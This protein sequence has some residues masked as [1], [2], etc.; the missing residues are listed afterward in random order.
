MPWCPSWLYNRRTVQQ[1]DYA[2]ISYRFCGRG[3]QGGK[4]LLP[5]MLR[6]SHDSVIQEAA[7]ELKNRYNMDTQR[8]DSR[9]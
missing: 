9:G 7:T 1:N 5:L 8:G 4:S 2:P 6:D 3:V